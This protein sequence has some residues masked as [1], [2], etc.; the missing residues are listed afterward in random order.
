MLVPPSW[1]P[2]PGVVCAACL[3]QM[4]NDAK[5]SCTTRFF[6]WCHCRYLTSTEWSTLYGGHKASNNEVGKR[7]QFRR[8]PFNCCRSGQ[9]AKRE[10]G[11][12]HWPVSVYLRLALIVVSVSRHWAKFCCVAEMQDKTTSENGSKRNNVVIC[13]CLQFVNAAG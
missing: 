1:I 9:K 3:S 10:Q 13:L 2:I 7:A 8:L 11:S 6:T 12:D 4:K 5:F